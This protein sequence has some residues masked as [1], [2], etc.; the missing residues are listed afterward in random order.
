MKPRCH[1]YVRD[2]STISER[3]CRRM[4]KVKRDGFWYCTQHD[5]VERAVRELVRDHLEVVMRH[6]VKRLEDKANE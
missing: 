3:H 4:G 6:V 1:E 2:C 5:P